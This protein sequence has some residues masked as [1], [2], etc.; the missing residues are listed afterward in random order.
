MKTV[1]VKGEVLA[2]GHL[3]LDVPCGLPP[4]P[5]E[6]CLVIQPDVETLSKRAP[7]FSTFEGCMAGQLPDDLD[8]EPMLNEMEQQWQESLLPK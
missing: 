7:R 6:V 5:V 3:R 4:G 8:I 2:D 1:M